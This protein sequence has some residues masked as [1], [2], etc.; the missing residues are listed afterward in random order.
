MIYR[1]LADCA[2]HEG[3]FGFAEQNYQEAIRLFQKEKNTE[4]SVLSVLYSSLASCLTMMHEYESA[5]KALGY[6]EKT[7][8]KTPEEQSARVI[9]YA[10]NG[11]YEKAES[12]LKFFLKQK[13]IRED[14]G[15]QKK[16]DDIRAGADEQFCTMSV[17]NSEI[18]AFRV[19]FSNRIEAF[20]TILDEDQAEDISEMTLE[21]SERLKQVFPFTQRSLHVS[22]YKDGSY[23]F[24]VSDF[25]AKALSDGLTELFSKMPERF[26]EAVRWIKI[27]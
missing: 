14:Y 7:E 25:Y 15:L 6:A 26:K 13:D 9:L 19:W 24:F 21:I 23:L 10:V 11:D 17:E 2:C 16:I 22:A 20:K 4:L 3:L 18:R 1:K 5:E 27:H 8:I 12:T